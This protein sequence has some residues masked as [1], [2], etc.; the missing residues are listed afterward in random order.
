MTV[1]TATI[2]LSRELRQDYDREL[3]AAGQSSWPSAVILELSDWLKDLWTTWLFSDQVATTPDR[4]LWPA[5]ERF[6]WEDIIRSETENQLLD[7]PATAKAALKSWDCYVT[8]IYL[9]M[10]RSGTIPRTP[11]PSGHGPRSS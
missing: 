11:L 4:L 9:W 10:Q 6:I 3:Q 7:I 8:G 1:I 2:R 5:E